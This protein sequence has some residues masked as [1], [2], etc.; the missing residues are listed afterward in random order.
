MDPFWK[1]FSEEF[2]DR[3]RDATPFLFTLAALVGLCVLAC[4]AEESGMGEYIGGGLVVAVI[5]AFAWKTVQH[6]RSRTRQQERW[7]RKELSCDEMRV[8][9][10][11]LKPDR[12]RKSA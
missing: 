7:E 10:S 8:A 4:I 9:R 11:K 2:K 6:L 3:G 1:T 5:L 12:N